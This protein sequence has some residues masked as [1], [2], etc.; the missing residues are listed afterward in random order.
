MSEEKTGR[1]IV[2]ASRLEDGRVVYWNKGKWKE[3]VENSQVAE[4]E[5]A[6][7]TMLAEASRSPEAVNAYLIAVQDNS[8][9]AFREQIRAKGPS[10]HPQLGK[11]GDN[12]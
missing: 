6:A 2:T 12:N 5:K 8:P 10:I 3:K 1:K 11:Q 4:S 7:E 9:V